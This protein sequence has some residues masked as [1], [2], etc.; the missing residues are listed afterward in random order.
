MAKNTGVVVVGGRLK[1]DHANWEF[2][3]T[4]SQVRKTGKIG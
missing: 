3:Y 1:I 4:K 2:S